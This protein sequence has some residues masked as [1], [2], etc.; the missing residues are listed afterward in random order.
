MSTN[1]CKFIASITPLLALS[2]WLSQAWAGQVQLAWNATTTHTDGTPA[3][4]LA[5]YQLHYWQGTGSPQS[6]DVGNQTTYTLTGLVDGQTYSLA[7][8][9]YNTAG[10]ESSDS[11]IVTWTVTPAN[12]APLADTASTP[13]GTPVAIDVLA[14]DTDPDGNPLTITAVTQGT[15]GTVTISG[16]TM[17]YTPAATFAGLDSFT[18]TISDGR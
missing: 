10:N 13:V 12:R 16:T 6:V 7:V 17:T 15:H 2:V 3:T 11:N 9:T 4:D 5:G 8:T 18:Y 14:N 1:F